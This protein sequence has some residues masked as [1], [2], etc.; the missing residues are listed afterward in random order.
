M[1]DEGGAREACSWHR[2]NALPAPR[3]RYQQPIM[4]YVGER[5][6][7]QGRIALDAFICKLGIKRTRGV[8]TSSREYPVL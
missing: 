3:L 6:L 1:L 2:H 7:Q 8:R 5:Q 4:N